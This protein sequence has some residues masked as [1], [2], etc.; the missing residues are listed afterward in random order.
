MRRFGVLRVGDGA[1]GDPVSGDCPGSLVVVE[2]EVDEPAEVD[3]GD[4]QGELRPVGFDALVTDPAVPV[5]NDPREGA[6]DHGPILAVVVDE[7]ATVPC[8]SRG[9]E[10][11]VV[12]G[13]SEAAS[14]L[15]CGASLT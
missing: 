13:D 1:G 11:V 9:D 6:F 7:H 15:C 10:F 4:A 14:V 12:V 3:G 8:S 5:G 2:A